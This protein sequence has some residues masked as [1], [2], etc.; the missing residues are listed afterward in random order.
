MRL[1]GTIP[2]FKQSFLEAIILRAIH[3]FP[4]AQVLALQEVKI[5][6]DRWIEGDDLEAL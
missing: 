2:T 3:E 5:G 6:L 4:L 1:A